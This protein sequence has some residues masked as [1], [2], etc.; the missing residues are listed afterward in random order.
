MNS[1]TVGSEQTIEVSCSKCVK[2]TGVNVIERCVHY[3]LLFCSF[4]FT[5]SLTL[6]ADLVVSQLQRLQSLVGTQ[7][8][9]DTRQ[10]AKSMSNSRQDCEGQAINR[11]ELV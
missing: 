11:I 10:K 3:S 4:I 6:I 2:N 9:I 7:S 8:L 1:V 5:A